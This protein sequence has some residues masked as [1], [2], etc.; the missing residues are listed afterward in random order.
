M[1]KTAM[2]RARTEPEVKEKAEAVMREI[3]L[4]PSAVITMLYRAII[5]AGG[6]P[7][8]P[9]ATTRAAMHE[10][11]TGENLTYADSMDEL[12]AGLSKG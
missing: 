11:A 8:Q 10:T 1:S 6:L 4:N 9:N 12:F 7:F 3:G 2:I 5:K